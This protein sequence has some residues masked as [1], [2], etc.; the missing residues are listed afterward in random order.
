MGV[1]QP[2]LS[3]P[4][5]LSDSVLIESKSARDQGL[6]A[7]T[8]QKSQQ[9][10]LNKV[11][12]VF[13]ALW[14][15]GEYMTT[16]QLAVFYDKPVD[17]IK[18]NRQRHSDEFEAD[19]VIFVE[20]D[21]LRELKQLGD[22]LSPSSQNARHA[23]LYPPR[24]VIRMGFILQGSEVAAQVRTAAL[25]LIQGVGHF[26]EPKV[27][28]ALLSGYPVLNSFAERGNLSI[29]APLA[30][31]YDAIESC[32]KKAFPDGGIEE[33]GK[34]GI[35]EKLAALSTYT[36]NWKFGTQKEMGYKLA[37]S[38]CAKYPDL[39]TQAFPIVVDGQPKTAVLM[40]Q[41][42]DLVVDERD[43]ELA[44]GRQYIKRATEALPVDYAFLFLI[45]PFGATPRAY[46]AIRRDL[47]SEMK[48]F[49][50]VMTVKEVGEALL[51]QAKAER[52]ASLVKGEI[53][54]AFSD[55]L[56]YEIPDPLLLMMNFKFNRKSS[57]KP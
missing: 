2:I 5:K 9:R 22:M 25:N 52:K 50:G 49:V 43:V 34:A 11:K 53:R 37:S 3:V 42:S 27:I 24:A 8:D 48:G 15:K 35:R 17:T 38:L 46:D 26:F 55:I 29:S 33:M 20:G 16:D 30:D 19:G 12:S 4:M 6:S 44:V 39:T 56:E 51:K 14:R 13:F 45:S 7:I 57:R 32:L 41:I 36:E 31:H 1:A 18:K 23:Y 54:K 47:P 40:F 10:L 28:D 21:D